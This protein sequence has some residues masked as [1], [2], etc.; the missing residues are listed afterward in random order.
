MI[1]TENSLAASGKAYG[2]FQTQ[3]LWESNI[4]SASDQIES[5]LLRLLVPIDATDE[6]RWGL[7]Y[8]LRK[9]RE[10]TRLE[11]VLLNIGEPVTQWQVLRFRTQQEVALFQS[12]RAQ[13][14][15]E[16]ASQYLAME[17]VPC[18]GLFRQGELAFSILDVAEE[19][20]CDEIV[21]PEPKKSLFAI[22]STGTVAA[23]LK[24][25]R[26]VPIVVVNSDGV[27]ANDPANGNKNS[28][29]FADQ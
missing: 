28:R 27:P 11:V 22:F 29:L 13:A 10:G 17:D 3:H 20:D 25:Q 7:Q 14:F 8:A 21:M 23:V 5:K 18:H 4:M 15:I 19:L 2:S 9:H 24:Q 1:R 26:D 12:E 16:Q 6:S